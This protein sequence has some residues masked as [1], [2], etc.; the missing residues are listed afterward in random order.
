MTESQ[1]IRCDWQ[2][3]NLSDADCSRT[4]F[5][6][7]RLA[8]CKLSLSNLTHTRWYDCR[9]EGCDFERSDLSG[10]CF[11]PSPRPGI[12]S[13]TINNC[14]LT[15]SNFSNADLRGVIGYQF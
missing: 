12:A 10:C 6:E 14:R 9:L 2:N 4:R 7:I 1:I 11:E 15:N 13:S 3:A 8:K 5:E